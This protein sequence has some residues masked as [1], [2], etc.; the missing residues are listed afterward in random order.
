MSENAIIK[1]YTRLAEATC[2][3]SCGGALEKSN[4]GSGEICIDLGSGRG[5]DVIRLAGI[6]GDG[7]FVY[8]VDSTPGM[9]KKGRDASDKL[10]IRN[11]EFVLSDLTKIPLASGTA[12]LIISNCVINHA[13]RKD[14]VWNEIYRLLKVGG[15]FVVSDIYAA[16]NVPFEY[17]SDP[18]MVAE[19]WA[20]AVTR[21]EFI[22]SVERAGFREINIIEESKPYEKG[23]ISVCSFTLSGIKK[24]G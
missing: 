5:T 8:G 23:K 15:R 14:E 17:S 4:A 24:E 16:E 11:V 20:G 10:G 19:C 2:C 6:V 21:D 3:L 22:A 7:G 13:D 12:D 18:V 9:I 1:R